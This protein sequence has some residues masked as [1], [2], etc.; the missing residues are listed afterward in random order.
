M[1]EAQDTRPPGFGA[2]GLPAYVVLDTSGSMAKYEPLL[3][4]T[5]LK[6]YDTLYT[7]PLLSE[8]IHLSVIS[9]NTQ[10]HVVTEMTDIE[11]ME[12][13]PTVTCEGL[14]NIGPMLRLLRTRITEDVEQLSAKGVKVLRPVVFL[15]TDGAPTDAPAGIWHQDLETL[16][17]P[18]WKPRPH[19]ITY[20]F[21]AASE[22]MLRSLAT[23]A[24]YLAQ[25]EAQS[26][27]EA[28]SEAMSSLLNSLVASARVQ[29]LQVP[30]EVKGYRSVPLD[31][32]D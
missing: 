23:V 12:S 7:S 15:L 25:D 5:L 22:S 11:L 21:G 26:T 14:T 32:V 16:R 24:A 28:L 17:D 18:A 13:L 30:E 29:Q 3:N 8:F 4:A 6:I 1:T 31:F 10:P 9:F 19:V 2:K 20:G 27:G